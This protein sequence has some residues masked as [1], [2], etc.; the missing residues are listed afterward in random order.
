MIQRAVIHRTLVAAA[1]LNLHRDPVVFSRDEMRSAAWSGDI[2]IRLMAAVTS[3]MGVLG[4]QVFTE[5]FLQTT[6]VSGLDVTMEQQ[7]LG[8]T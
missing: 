5:S 7:S 1:R 6:K 3:E 8:L 4:R 2:F